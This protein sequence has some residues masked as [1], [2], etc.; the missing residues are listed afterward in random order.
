[1]S[2]KAKI[3]S[4][5]SQ[6]DNISPK[7][8]M[9]HRGYSEY[10]PDL[11]TGRLRD[12]V[13]ILFH[14]SYCKEVAFDQHPLLTIGSILG[15]ALRRAEYMSSRNLVLL[16]ISSLVPDD[17]YEEWMDEEGASVN[18]E[19]KISK[20]V[21][22]ILEK[23][24]LANATVVAIGNCCQLLL[25]IIPTV[26]SCGDAGH[27]LNSENVSRL[28]FIHP[29]LPSR[30]I[31]AQFLGT[32]STFA[33]NVRA[34][35]V[36]PSDAERDRRLLILRSCFVKGECFVKLATGFPELLISALCKP[37]PIDDAIIEN[38]V[39]KLTD[40]DATN[41]VGE[42][43][44][45][46]EVT[47]AMNRNSKQYEQI[48]TDLTRDMRDLFIQN[49]KKS[50]LA[51]AALLKSGPGAGTVIKSG[52]K[53]ACSSSAGCV[54][55][56]ERGSEVG[57]LV[58]RGNRCVLVRSQTGSWEGL[59]IPSVS[60][61]L[62][63]RPE[64]TAVRAVSELC[65]IDSDEFYVLSN[66][67]PTALYRPTVS[68]SASCIIT[69]YV[70]YAIQPPPDGALEEQD[71]EDVDDL[72]DWYTW[73]RAVEA[74]AS[75]GDENSIFTMRSIA[76]ALAAASA[77]SGSDYIPRKWGGI[78]G[79]E[80]IYSIDDNSNMKSIESSR[81]MKR[82]N[83]SKFTSGKMPILIVTGAFGSGKSNLLQYLLV[84]Q[85]IAA[86]VALIINSLASNNLDN[87]LF[88]Q[89]ED[90]EWYSY[91][92]FEMNG[93]DASYSSKREIQK[94]VQ[95]IAESKEYDYCVI[96]AV[97]TAD[98]ESL[99]SIL[100]EGNEN[101]CPY[102]IDNTVCVVDAVNSLLTLKNR[103]NSPLSTGIGAVQDAI[104]CRQ[105]RA[106]AVIVINRCDQLGKGA[107]R[108]KSIAA[109]KAVIQQLNQH[110]VIVVATFGDVDP[111][112]LMYT[113]RLIA[114]ANKLLPDAPT[115]TKVSASD[116]NVGTLIFRAKRPFHPGR[117]DNAMRQMGIASEN[118]TLF[119]PQSDLVFRINGFM[120]V[121]NY[122]DNQCLLSYTKGHTYES[123]LG[124]QWW[125][126]VDKR[127]W[128]KG[129]QEAILP[130]WHAP[131]G[132]RQ[133]ELTFFGLFPSS[134]V[135]SAIEDAMSCCL[136]TDEEFGLGQSMW[137]EMDDPFSYTFV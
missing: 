128:P 95:K 120:W 39:T 23:M 42:T 97:A 118:G 51:S 91:K 116:P 103:I 54:P 107:A 68:G 104:I 113:R 85:G 114:K 96:E 65:D 9:A 62:N 63:E 90:D 78:F 13:V 12:A 80:W 76:C 4:E 33:S 72:Y 101:D 82:E 93:Y 94:E 22:R 57:G 49:K 130:L 110:A 123:Q 112:T 18:S 79:Q 20:P 86:R 32:P 48:A 16:D 26:T 45:M 6:E 135:R 15:T 133:I 10:K 1:M 67:P 124:T 88:Q 19:K 66:I 126:T 121:A 64:E 75:I 36:F 30:C 69:V 109:I 3:I 41:T 43:V 28:I 47:I 81:E 21:C 60:A 115:R 131:Y 59:K 98:L 89:S 111:S 119:V 53:L 117:L 106:S 122:P 5:I 25:K 40:L 134:E 73:H 61:L 14:R 100:L 37:Q 8:W 125:A 17:K 55:T 71:K 127:L 87:A 83:V 137:N 34:D 38:Y 58:L 56:A 52:S 7:I 105:V 108:T 29:V 35:F 132:D 50:K 24:L 77:C 129:L 46:S 74:F 102:Y 44:W 92:L 84:N 99:I 31:N 70:M 27:K 2:R 11:K 136:L